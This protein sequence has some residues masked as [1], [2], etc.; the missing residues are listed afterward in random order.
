[1]EPRVFYEQVRAYFQELWT[2]YG[3]STVYEMYPAGSFGLS[4]LVLGSEAGRIRFEVEY[5][6]LE[7]RIS[8]ARGH[9]S[10]PNGGADDPNETWLRIQDV[11]GLLGVGSSESQPGDVHHVSDAEVQQLLERVSTEAG[12]DAE[13]NK[14]IER[15]AREL[16]PH[17]PKIV[18]RLRDAES[19]R[20]WKELFRSRKSAEARANFL[21]ELAYYL[22]PVLL[23]AG[24]ILSLV[25]IQTLFPAQA[26]QLLSALA[27]ITG[28]LILGWLLAHHNI[29]TSPANARRR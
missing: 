17:W 22:I 29:S 24:T 8:L 16:S 6:D 1:M 28:L 14:Q 21:S 2:V 19:E 26:P 18:A 23:G 9:F 11:L 5:H 15:W 27:L 7:L 20:R 10:A 13:V 25:L 12:M 3:F 4:Q